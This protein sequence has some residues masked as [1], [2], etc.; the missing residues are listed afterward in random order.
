V[1]LAAQ[2]LSS[3]IG[4]RQRGVAPCCCSW[5]TG[6]AC[7]SQ[8]VRRHTHIG[9]PINIMNPDPALAEHLR[10]L[11]ESMTKPEV[12]RSPEELAQLLANDFREFGSSGRVFDKRQIIEALQNQPAIQLWLDEFQV[13]WLAPDVA[14]VTY[15]GNCRFPDSDKVSHSLRSSIWRNR[16]GRWEVVFHQGTSAQ[17]VKA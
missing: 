10:K 3:T 11:E 5:L 1:A 15:R 17:G 4:S 14:L 12:R 9:L 6:P 2:R 7:L 13:K 16:D 8:N